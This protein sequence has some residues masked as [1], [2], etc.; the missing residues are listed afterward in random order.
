MVAA[1]SHSRQA[2]AFVGRPLSASSCSE[3]PVAE[4]RRRHGWVPIAAGDR[5]VCEPHQHAQCKY[6]TLL[7]CSV[8]YNACMPAGSAC[9]LRPAGDATHATASP[10]MMPRVHAVHLHMVEEYIST[11]GGGGPAVRG[12][13]YQFGHLLREVAGEHVGSGPALGQAACMR[14][15]RML[16]DE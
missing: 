15:G 10:E 13:D 12:G 8:L 11:G 9:A 1:P 7:E 16:S 4:S 6:G 14:R 3:I 2:H 5:H